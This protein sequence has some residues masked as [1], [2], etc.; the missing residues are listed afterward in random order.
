MAQASWPHQIQYQHEFKA[1]LLEMK[2]A[3]CRDL[4]IMLQL[5]LLL[6]INLQCVLGNTEKV[7]FLAPESLH[8][9]VEHPTVEDLQ[10][11]ALSPQHWSLRTEIRAEFPTNTSKYGQP[12]WYLLQNLQKGQRY[13]VRIC[14]AATVNSYYAS[15]PM[16]TDIRQQ[17]T[18]F[19]LETYELST[20]FET[21]DLIM[22]LA[23]YSETRQPDL[24]DVESE[25]S[26]TKREKQVK[27]KHDD[28]SSIIL[29][30]ILAAA[31]YY[32]TNK[33]LMEHV[34]PVAVDIILDPYIYNVFPRS[35]IPT[36]AYIVILAVGGWFVAKYI[37]NFVRSIGQHDTFA[38]KKKV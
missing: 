2:A 38:R 30:Q 28:S 9:P 12:S 27:H 37:S 13:E 26:V 10:L 23:Q 36:A 1:G 34:P 21:P 16:V 24:L 33:T 3:V 15:A 4:D 31:D 11:D 18:S 17:P 22:S 7:I 6:F 25:P 5:L 19:R 35:L 8:V 29:L 32:T 20:V 14:W